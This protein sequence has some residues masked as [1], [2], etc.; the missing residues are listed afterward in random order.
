[1]G[2]YR[3][4]AKIAASETAER[5]GFRDQV[6]YED[7]M[8]RSCPQIRRASRGALIPTSHDHRRIKS[9]V[10]FVFDCEPEACSNKT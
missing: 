8:F 9:D 4:P 2:R 7:F 3:T 6:G 5:P 1:V 10:N